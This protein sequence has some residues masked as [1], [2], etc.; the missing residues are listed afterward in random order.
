MET[1][2]ITEII[3]PEDKDTICRFCLNIAE[4]M[5]FLNESNEHIWQKIGRISIQKV[6]RKL[7]IKIDQADFL[8]ACICNDCKTVLE[9]FII[10]VENIQ[11]N[12]DLLKSI[13]TDEVI[14]DENGVIVSKGTK[15]INT[16]STC[17]NKLEFIVKQENDIKWTIPSN[18]SDTDNEF[19]EINVVNSEFDITASP[20]SSE[21]NFDYVDIKNIVSSS[22]DGEKEFIAYTKDSSSEIHENLDTEFD[23]YKFCNTLKVELR[24]LGRKKKL[25]NIKSTSN[26][27]INKKHIIVKKKK[28]KRIRKTLHEE[29]EI[30]SIKQCFFCPRKFS[31]DGFR[32]LHYVDHVVQ[33]TEGTVPHRPFCIYC[34]LVPSTTEDLE[35]HIRE[36]HENDDDL[37]CHECQI[38]FSTISEVTAHEENNHIEHIEGDS[39]TS[40][41]CPICEKEFDVTDD[42]IKHSLEHISRRYTCIS[43]KKIFVCEAALNEH[44]KEHPQYKFK[45]PICN[46]LVSGKSGLRA[47]VGTHATTRNYECDICGKRYKT[48]PH[49]LYHRSTHFKPDFICSQCAYATPIARDFNTHLR[50]HSSERPYQCT[51]TDCGKSFKTNSALSSHVKQHL[52]IKNF[53]CDMCDYKTS[54]SVGLTLHKRKHTGERPYVCMFCQKTFNRKWSLTLHMRKLHHLVDTKNEKEEI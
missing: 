20:N 24:D 17:N 45:C 38:R 28:K 32:I 7:N 16:Q 9:D 8:P 19:E 34:G 46:K 4:E 26:K 15:G 2:E 11:S 50:S 6:L 37:H 41:K 35:E 30:L 1:E 14:S 52:N 27:Q 49:L 51:F 13:Y 53:A 44:H 10:F 29:P 21:S 31:S 42:L 40:N 43:C 54:R 36:N 33:A 39:S 47:H 12:E 48:K 25:K 22:I 3:I 5:T 18:S 23:K